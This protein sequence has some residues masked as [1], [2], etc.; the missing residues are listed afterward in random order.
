VERRGAQHRPAQPRLGEQPFRC[1]LPAV[2]RERDPVDADDRLV[3]HA[4]A[5][6]ALGGSDQVARDLRVV[7][8][9]RGQVQHRTHALERGVDALAGREV[10][11][12][13]AGAAGAAEHTHVMAV[14]AE[15][16]D[17]DAPE[18]AGSPGHEDGSGRRGHPNILPRRAGLVVRRAASALP[19]GESTRARVPR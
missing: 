18:R 13:R 7:A 11:A 12:N 16:A 14:G 17:G 10:A 15:A 4:R 1:P 9:R 5:A 8:Q 2:V 3:D 6:G 19:V